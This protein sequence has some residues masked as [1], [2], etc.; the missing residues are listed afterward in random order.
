MDKGES[1][2]GRHEVGGLDLKALKQAG[3][4]TKGSRLSNIVGDLVVAMS[5]GR[6]DV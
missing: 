1:V 4:W 6:R 3:L 5:Y 2:G